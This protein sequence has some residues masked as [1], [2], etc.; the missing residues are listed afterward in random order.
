[1]KNQMNAH[2]LLQAARHIPPP[3]QASAEEYASLCEI[4]SAS[5]TRSMLNSPHIAELIGGSAHQ[6]MMAENHRNHGLFL[7]VLLRHYQAEYLVDTVLW[8]Y[9]AY[10]SHGFQRLYWQ[11]QLE[12]WQNILQEHLSD[13][14]YREISPIYQFLLHHQDD[15]A[16]LSQEVHQESTNFHREFP[17]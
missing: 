16:R 5:V 11:V 9:R 8:V 10:M 15:F 4:L 17:I 7:C 13:K 12:T 1:M 14:A 2:D 3:S 6:D